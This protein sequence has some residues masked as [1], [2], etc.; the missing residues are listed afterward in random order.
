MSSL[1]IRNSLTKNKEPF[2]PWKEDSKLVT[3]YICG[4]TVYDSAHVGHARNYLSFDTIRRILEGYFGYEVE[5]QMNVTDVD[6]KI[7]KKSKELKEDFRVISGRY[8]QEFWEDLDKLNCIFP[9]YVSRVTDYIP[10]IITF[11]ERLVERGYAYEAEGSV[12]FDVQTFTQAGFK[13]G[14]LEPTSVGDTER[15]MEGEGSWASQQARLEKKSAGDFA[16]WKKSQVDEPGWQS[17]WGYGRPGWHV[18]C[19][20]MASCIFGSHLDMHCGGED[21]RFPHHENEIA[22]SEAYFEKDGW[23]K[24]FL[25]S[26]HL[27]IEGLKMSKSLKNFITIRSILERYTARQLRL[28]ILQHHYTARMNYSEQGMQEAVNVERFFAEFFRNFFALE[29]EWKKKTKMCRGQKYG[30][31]GLSS[32]FRKRKEEIHQALCDDFDTPLVIRSLQALVKTT[33]LY[34][35]SETIEDIDSTLMT[36]IVRYITKILTILGLGRPSSEELGFGN[37]VPLQKYS[38]QEFVYGLIDIFVDSRDTIRGLLIPLLKQWQKG[39]ALIEKD[40]SSWSVDRMFVCILIRTEKLWLLKDNEDLQAESRKLFAT[41]M[42]QGSRETEQCLDKLLNLLVKH[43]ESLLTT[44]TQISQSSRVVSGL[45]CIKTVVFQSFESIFN[46]LDKLS[47]VKVSQDDLKSFLSYFSQFLETNDGSEAKQQLLVAAA[48]CLLRP[49]LQPTKCILEELDNIR[50]K[51]L[52]EYGIRIEDSSKGSR[53]KM[54]DPE[55]LKKEM[56]AKEQQESAKLEEK[57]RKQEE[58]QKRL[59]EE[60]DRGRVP[61]HEMFRQGNWQGHFSKYDADGIP[62]HDIENNE[63]PKSQRKKLMK[64]YEKQ[65]K[66]H[67]NYLRSLNKF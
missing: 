60:L 67:E 57:K 19:S 1:V 4:P 56:V 61:P 62:T 26:G 58:A 39:T 37:E 21:L 18:E 6:D 28:F 51:K 32:E 10:E 16:L 9:T 23:V 59:L 29:R 36:N 14:Q 27:H 3:C 7:I 65:R 22:Q 35:Q 2:R 8:E 44:E 48:K 25:H 31:N 41:F 52:I 17:P 30:E 66:L 12:Y 13:Y 40:F 55:E 24:F 20:A 64:E 33:N 49:Y 47:V 53:W 46:L 38:N 50:D 45:Y 34:I 43:L 15:L 42:S 11:I 63:I 54:E 5:L